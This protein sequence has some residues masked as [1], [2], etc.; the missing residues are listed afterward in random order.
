MSNESTPDRIAAADKYDWS[1]MTRRLCRLCWC[2]TAIRHDRSYI[3]SHQF[4]CHL[5]QLLV[6]AFSPAI[7]DGD[8][9][10]DDIAGALEAVRE[11]GDIEF[12]GCGRPG[13]DKP[14]HR[15][16]RLLRARRKRPRNSRAAK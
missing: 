9:L 11:A 14:D 6:M 16:R 13:A 15:H 12:V 5:E 10:P 2:I 1:S 8:I 3:A 4:G 7:L